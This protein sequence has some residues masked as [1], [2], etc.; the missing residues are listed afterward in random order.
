MVQNGGDEMKEVSLNRKSISLFLSLA[1]G[2]VVC[3]L[4]MPVTA[5]AAVTEVVP[6]LYVA[7]N[8]ITGKPYIGSTVEVKLDLWVES[9]T[10]DWDSWMERYFAW[11]EVD[12]GGK[13]MWLYTPKDSSEDIVI[14]DAVFDTMGRSELLL[15]PEWYGGYIKVVYYFPDNVALISVIEVSVE[16][17]HGPS[18]NYTITKDYHYSPCS[19]RYCRDEKHK[20]YYGEHND[21]DGDGKCDVCGMTEITSITITGSFT[22]IELGNLVNDTSRN[23]N[24]KIDSPQK[25]VFGA[26]YIEWYVPNTF[27][28]SEGEIRGDG[29]KFRNLLN[30]VYDRDARFE[31]GQLY[32]GALRLDAYRDGKF[33]EDLSVTI[34]GEPAT[35]FYNE[36]NE[37]IDVILIFK[38]FTPD[39]NIDYTIPDSSDVCVEYT[40]SSDYKVY[41]DIYRYDEGHSSYS[42]KNGIWT[43]DPKF[44]EKYG[45]EEDFS[46]SLKNAYIHEK[47]DRNCNWLT[48]YEDGYDYEISF[49]VASNLGNKIT[50][51]PNNITI[52]GDKYYLSY[53]WS[54]GVYSA[55]IPIHPTTAKAGAAVWGYSLTLF[56]QIGVNFHM[57]LS[58]AAMKD[59]NA[60]MVFNVAGE[61]ERIVSIKDSTN[62]IDYYSGRQVYIFSCTVAPKQM[63]DT[64]TAQFFMSDG[65]SSKVYSFS[66]EEYILILYGK[67][68]YD[69]IS[70]KAV[71]GLNLY[72]YYSQL[73]FGYN[74]DNLV[75]ISNVN[76]DTLS[77]NMLSTLKISVDEFDIDT[78]NAKLS[79]MGVS[80]LGSSLVLDTKAKVKMY[81]TMEDDVAA[82]FMSGAATIGDG[83]GGSY[84]LNKV[85]N[86]VYYIESAP[87][88]PTEVMNKK[89]NITFK[90]G[91]RSES[92]VYS[93]YQYCNMALNSDHVDEKL[94]NLINAY[95][96]YTY[97]TYRD[98]IRV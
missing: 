57:D 81:L 10:D 95:I 5:F 41:V 25:D 76:A 59:D 90:A 35:F 7:D 28:I 60:Y 44:L 8:M 23:A 87:L 17:G 53:D 14:T 94:Q 93:P 21:S 38:R 80:I 48:E 46:D 43:N 34:N 58:E 29:G 22:D 24:I 82:A 50:A 97:W 26:G 9:N 73:Y 62:Y 30:T 12:N 2:L 42:K 32:V 84:R 88:M 78:I 72:G 4:L 79:P 36:Y 85:A 3:W 96:Y 68:Y 19:Y 63:T 56:E 6:N 1:L 75:D 92:I 86:G 49:R 71:K 18:E 89:I 61:A 37:Y 11:E 45:I 55:T 77:S 51:Y 47:Y 39:L 40:Y 31:T 54:K 27:D 13:C 64:I 83:A 33:S 67:S 91:G 66:I 74:T 69:D 52:N 15:K 70:F 20:F 98:S 65:T 16:D